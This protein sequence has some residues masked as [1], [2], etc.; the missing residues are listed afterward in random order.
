[1]STTAQKQM[2]ANQVDLFPS[3]VMPRQLA[4]E[5]ALNGS[6]PE[7]TCPEY[8]LDLERWIGARPDAFLLE[9]Q[10]NRAM[11]ALVK[12][13]HGVRPEE[14]LDLVPSL[15]NPSSTV[16]AELRKGF[17]DACDH[18]L[19]MAFVPHRE[20][21]AHAFRE[22]GV[23]EGKDLLK[24]LVS[25]ARSI[26]GD[27]PPGKLPV[28]EDLMAECI[29]KFLD[30]P[31]YRR[32]GGPIIFVRDER[33]EYLFDEC[34]A[35]VRPGMFESVQHQVGTTVLRA[36]RSIAEN[37]QDESGDFASRREAFHKNLQ[38]SI[39]SRLDV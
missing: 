9:F 6:L 7:V 27:L 21:R 13:V 24:R 19:R 32:R 17:A 36:L 33:W 14:I 37:V 3:E 25:T 20:S 31:F 4:G 16:S 10:F 15:K 23:D 18:I 34:C 35:V 30:T 2:P 39:S 12:D 1:M 29:I 38:D 11:I 26:Q 8:L 22:P 28:Y 5:S